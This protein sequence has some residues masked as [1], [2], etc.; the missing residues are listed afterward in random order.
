MHDYGIE[1]SSINDAAEIWPK[2]VGI[3]NFFVHVCCLNLVL[4]LTYGREPTLSSRGQIEA[5]DRSPPADRRRSGSHPQQRHGSQ[6]AIIISPGQIMV[7]LSVQLA[8]R[9]SNAINRFK[10]ND[11][12]QRSSIPNPVWHR[13]VGDVWINARVN[14]SQ[15]ASYMLQPDSQQLSPS[16]R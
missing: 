14:T 5:K 1:I 10:K 7:G 12:S 11:A 16:S 13:F 2:R 3:V 6:N 9:S 4:F 8:Q 15:G